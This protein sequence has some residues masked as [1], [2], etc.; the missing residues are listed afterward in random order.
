M[1]TSKFPTQKSREFFSRSR[2]FYRRSREFAAMQRDSAYRW[3][4]VKPLLIGLQRNDGLPHRQHEPTQRHHALGH[5]VA[6]DREDYEVSP[7]MRN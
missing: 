1:F 4:P 2:E 5:G 6:N 3:R 7:S